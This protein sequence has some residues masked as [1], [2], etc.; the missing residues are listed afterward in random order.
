[1][2]KIRLQQKIKDKSFKAK[3]KPFDRLILKSALEDI[4]S[5]YLEKFS[6][7]KKICQNLSVKNKKIFS[8]SS[9]ISSDFYKI[10]IAENKK[11]N[12]IYTFDHGGGLRAK[13]DCQVNHEAIISNK[14]YTWSNLGKIYQNSHQTSPYKIIK[15]ANV[16]NF[17]NQKNFYNFAKKISNL[18]F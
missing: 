15:L 8:F 5:N 18:G 6:R 16:T 7:L 12:K 1:M 14:I 17:K 2:I 13:N 10:W 11:F 3:L 4:P 9:Q